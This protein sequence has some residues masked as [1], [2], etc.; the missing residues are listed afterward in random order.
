M[1]TLIQIFY[2]FLE[3]NKIINSLISRLLCK[4]VFL[5]LNLVQLEWTLQDNS[6]DQNYVFLFVLVSVAT[7]TSNCF[8]VYFRSYSKSSTFLFKEHALLWNI[9]RDLFLFAIFSG[10]F[11]LLDLEFTPFPMS[12]F[13]SGLVSLN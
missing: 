3:F 4:L 6:W 12:L 7:A 9:E 2:I 11:I 5:K 8:K 13:T 1:L 10:C